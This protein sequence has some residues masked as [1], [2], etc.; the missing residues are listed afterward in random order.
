MKT[1]RMK[2]LRIG[3]RSGKLADNIIKNWLIGL[4]ESNPAILDM[5]ADRDKPP[6]RDLLPWSGEFSGKY[7]TGAYYI[8]RLTLD[9]ELY[10]YIINFIDEL[11]SYQDEDGYLGCFCKS[12]HLTGRFSQYSES[13]WSGTWD[14]WSLYHNMF[15]LLL[16][17]RETGNERYLETV[18]RAAELFMKT[19]YNPENRNRSMI[20]MGASEMNLSVYHAFALLYSLTGMRKYR[21]FAQNIENDLTRPEAGNYLNHALMGLEFWQCPKPRWESLHVIL[22]IAESYRGTGDGKYLDAARQICYSILKTDIHSTGAF[23]TNE[24]AVG[25]PFKTG[26]IETCCVIAYNALVVEIFKLTGDTALLDHLDHSHYNACMGLWSPSG[27]WSTYD[28]PMNGTKCASTQTIV[29]QSRP[30]SPELNCCAVNAARSVGMLSEWAVTED[31]DTLYLNFFEKAFYETENGAKITVDSVYPMEGEIRITVT[32]YCGLF[33]IRIPGWADKATVTINSEPVYP[34]AGA[35]FVVECQGALDIRLVLN[36]STRFIDGED[37][38]LG[39]TC[40]LRGSLLFGTD[41]VRS[42]DFDLGSMPPLSRKEISQTAAVS[43]KEAVCIPLKNGIT[44]CDFYNLGT[45]GSQYVSWMK[46]SD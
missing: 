5:H 13:R 45:T 25:T 44:L 26:G 30:G 34:Q 21:D 33:G 29:F 22:G 17:Y 28:T 1:T 4:R 7:I 16:W 24:R 41:T 6:Y 18:I 9:R 14:S 20:E 27:R 46:I 36:F 32:D 15:G 23:S 3:G 11:I 10:D 35:Y 43:E 8:Y 39:D 42:G 19:F 31:E 40:V 37:D 12:C 2:N 38:F